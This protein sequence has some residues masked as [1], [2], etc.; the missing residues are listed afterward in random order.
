[1]RRRRPRSLSLR[2]NRG[3]RNV[4]C[5]CLAHRSILS[6]GSVFFR[7]RIFF[8]RRILFRGSGVSDRRRGRSLPLGASRS[9]RVLLRVS[10]SRTWPSQSQT[11]QKSEDK[12]HTGPRKIVLHRSKERKGSKERKEGLC[13]PP[14]QAPAKGSKQK[15]PGKR[16][17]F[18]SKISCLKESTRCRQ[19]RQ[20]R[21]SIHF[22]VAGS[23]HQT[24]SPPQSVRQ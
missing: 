10:H 22:P 21:G 1:M 11:N 20:Q 24:A 13:H 6:S 9:R 14:Y 18:P 8:G 15:K 12:S 3:S 4:L 7:R 23:P 17:R 16:F 5:G 19:P 2:T